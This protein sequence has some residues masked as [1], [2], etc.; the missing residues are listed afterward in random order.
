MHCC[1]HSSHGS[2]NRS[3]CRYVRKC[4]EMLNAEW[5]PKERAMSLK[6]N[7]CML[8]TLVILNDFVARN[9][10]DVNI[11]NIL[12]IFIVFVLNKYSFFGIIYVNRLV[13]NMLK[14]LN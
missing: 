12:Y 11:G 4:S 9:N 5:F 14:R 10:D 7:I 8:F 2:S 6:V 1:A 13:K 3:A